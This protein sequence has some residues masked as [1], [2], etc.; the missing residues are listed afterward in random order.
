MIRGSILSNAFTTSRFKIK[1]S[2]PLS[3]LCHLQ[4]VL[5]V[6]H[7]DLGTVHFLPR[8]KC[9]LDDMEMPFKWQRRQFPVRLAFAMTINKSQGH[10]LKGKCGVYVRVQLWGRVRVAGVGRGDRFPSRVAYL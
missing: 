4:E 8:I 7:A 9:I 3:L 6:I 5:R 2:N 10:T 1:V